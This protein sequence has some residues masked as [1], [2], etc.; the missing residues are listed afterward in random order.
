MLVRAEWIRTVGC[1]NEKE[2]LICVD[3][4]DLSAKWKTGNRCW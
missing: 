3:S 4:Q 1:G 2:S